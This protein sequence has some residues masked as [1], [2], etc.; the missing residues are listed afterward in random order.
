M[1]LNP[2]NRIVSTRIGAVGFVLLGY[3]RRQERLP[4]IVAGVALMEYPYFVAGRGWIL[5]V[6]VAIVAARCAAIRAELWSSHLR[7]RARDSAAARRRSA[8][9]GTRTA[10]RR[11]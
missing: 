7:G 11:G 3:G 10:G 2:A 1:D 8:G 6:G 5:A 4:Q 9:D